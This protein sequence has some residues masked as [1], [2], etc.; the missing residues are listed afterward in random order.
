[1]PPGMDS[2]LAEFERRFTASHCDAMKD[3][4]ALKPPNFADLLQVNFVLFFYVY[5]IIQY[6]L[7][8][9]L[10]LTL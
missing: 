4:Q 6:C 1:M 8:F 3:I 7:Y 9:V 5:D 10:V 2:L